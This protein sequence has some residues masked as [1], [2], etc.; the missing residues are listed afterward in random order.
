MSESPVLPLA[1]ALSLAIEAVGPCP[2]GPRDEWWDRVVEVAGELPMIL[3]RVER[4][5]AGAPIKEVR[6]RGVVERVEVLELGDAGDGRGVVWFHADGGSRF[7]SG[8]ERLTTDWLSTSTGRR[9]FEAARSLVG[10]R[11]EIV[12]H[13]VP[14]LLRGQPVRRSDGS[15]ETTS[16]LVAIRPLEDEAVASSPALNGHGA[17]SPARQRWPDEELG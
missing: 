3:G 7:G 14:K 16:R 17:P 9:L 5:L 10:R 6:L 2:D 11:V 12:R 13:Q 4:A 8:P 1:A 15:V